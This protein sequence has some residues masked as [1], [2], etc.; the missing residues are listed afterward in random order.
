MTGAVAAT[1]VPSYIFQIRKELG[2]TVKV[3]LSAGASNFVTPYALKIH[4]GHEVF[5][6]NFESYEDTLV[7]HIKLTKEADLL[8]VMPAT[9][10]II[11]KAAYGICDDQVS[12]SI[13]AAKC[14]ILF[15]PSMN[16]S[17]WNDKT[18]KQN[19]ERL[20][21]LD[22]YLLEPRRGTEIDGLEETYGVMPMLHE[23]VAAIKQI[24]GQQ[25]VPKQ[26]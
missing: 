13:V 20:L 9:A 19:I 4:S 21:E 26:Q 18:V 6:N 5:T 12:T 8:L 22:Y 3:I 11:A 16:F 7:P 25:Q 17:M 23:I 2:C 14:P 10:N 24:L 15:L 1:V